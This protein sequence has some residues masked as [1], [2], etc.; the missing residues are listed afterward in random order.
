MAIDMN[1]S[2]LKEILRCAQILRCF[3]S[4][5][6]LFFSAHRFFRHVGTD[7][8]AFCRVRFLLNLVL[9]AFGFIRAV[10]L[11]VW[12]TV[13]IIARSSRGVISNVDCSQYADL[14]VVIESPI[15]DTWSKVP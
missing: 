10:P 8:R 2:I 5:Y 3:K 9:L 11:F 13:D 15:I 4:K 7:V 14:P 6:L 1:Y 12:V